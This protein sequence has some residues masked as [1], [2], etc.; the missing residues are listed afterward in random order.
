M[1]ERST[2]KAAEEPVAVSGAVERESEI[3]SE[4]GLEYS[5]AK[6]CF[7]VEESVRFSLYEIDLIFGVQDLWENQK[8]VFYICKFY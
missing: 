3:D 4:M 7:H 6:F 5:G 2:D 1:S 8:S